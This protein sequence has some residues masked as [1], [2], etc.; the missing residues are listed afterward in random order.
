L[1]DSRDQL[2]SLTA[3]TLTRDHQFAGQLR[4]VS[5]SPGFR[6]GTS[7]RSETLPS[8]RNVTILFQPQ[9]IS[10]YLLRRRDAAIRIVNKIGTLEDLSAKEVE[11]RKMYSVDVPTLLRSQARFDINE[12]A[13][14]IAASVTVPFE[15]E[16]GLFSVKPE[17]A[18]HR[19]IGPRATIDDGRWGSSGGPMISLA[20][21]FPPATSANEVKTW[22]KAE[23]DTIEAW[24]SDMAPDVD[25]Y[26]G[27][28]DEFIDDLVEQRRAVVATAESLRNELEDGI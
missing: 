23:I 12:T 21:T 8:V 14:G 2:G 27:T 28:I 22:A 24:L 17:N 16:S 18:G 15:G 26:N 20:K 25:A 6:K 10:E 13:D 9:P 11:L 3:R 5:N 7:V 19:G 4:P 1:A